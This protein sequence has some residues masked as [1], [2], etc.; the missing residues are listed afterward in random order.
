MVTGAMRLEEGFSARAA[1][2]R[3]FLDGGC[4]LFSCGGV[5]GWVWFRGELFE[6]A[7]VALFDDDG[8][9]LFDDDGVE[10]FDDRGVMREEGVCALRRMPLGPRGLLEDANRRA[11]RDNMMG[12]RMNVP[13]QKEGALSAHLILDGRCLFLTPL[14]GPVCQSLDHPYRRI[15]QSIIHSSVHSFT[16]VALA[17]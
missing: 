10:L 8:V 9:A 3:A 13:L 11:V 7:G 5:D 1:A 14:F 12:G 15:I 4:W 17:F 2:M 6:E 16:L